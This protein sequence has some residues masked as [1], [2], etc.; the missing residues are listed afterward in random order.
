MLSRLRITATL[1]GNVQKLVGRDARTQDT[2]QSR[3]RTLLRR[4]LGT[5]RLNYPS[6]SCIRRFDPAG[7]KTDN[8]KE[9]SQALRSHHASLTRS[10]RD[11]GAIVSSLMLFT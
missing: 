10:V 1:T 7:S 9:Q 8:K 2:S 6:L 5:G 3:C 11:D 4:L